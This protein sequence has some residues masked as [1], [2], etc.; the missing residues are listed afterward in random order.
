MLAKR[1]VL[2]Y[3]KTNEEET[4]CIRISLGFANFQERD[5]QHFIV[6]SEGPQNNWVPTYRPS[7]TL[8]ARM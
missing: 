1:C 2:L 3:K 5:F 6:D 7:I 8:S 4:G